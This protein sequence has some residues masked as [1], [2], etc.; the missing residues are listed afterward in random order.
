MKQ[1]T[2]D[3][4]MRLGELAQKML[5]FSQDGD[6]TIHCGEC[7]KAFK[8]VIVPT[9]QKTEEGMPVFKVDLECEYCDY[10]MRLAN[11]TE[12]SAGLEVETDFDLGAFVEE[13]RDEEQE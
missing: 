8:T 13:L 11:S 5:R 7:L 10:E 2:D 6:L 1:L 4:K 9:L 3:E 12:V